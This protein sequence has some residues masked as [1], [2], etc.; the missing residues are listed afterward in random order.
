MFKVLEQHNHNYM[1]LFFS[2][3]AANNYPCVENTEYYKAY[4]KSDA[5]QKFVSIN[6]KETKAAS[7]TAYF[8]LVFGKFKMS[9]DQKGKR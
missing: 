2:F 4:K 3:K 8:K 6:T 7:L 5:K 9:I 1:K